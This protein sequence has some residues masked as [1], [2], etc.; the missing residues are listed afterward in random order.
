MGK[1]E[2]LYSDR[3]IQAQNRLEE[4]IAG[5]K[6]EYDRVVGIIKD[7]AAAMIA[8]AEVELPRQISGFYQFNGEKLIGWQIYWWGSYDYTY[9]YLLSNGEFVYS[10]S[11]VVIDPILFDFG[12]YSGCLG[13]T[14]QINGCRETKL[15]RFE[16]YSFRHKM[17][18]IARE[19][20]GLSIKQEWLDSIYTKNE[21]SVAYA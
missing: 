20:F 4:T 10:E 9:I 3:Q 18:Q 15:D 13:P 8:K 21:V 2:D 14:S 11:A 6:P 17:V 1:I 5:N 16:I 7:I 19:T 12:T